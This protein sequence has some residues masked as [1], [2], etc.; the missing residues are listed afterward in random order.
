MAASTTTPAQA[1]K[2]F[3]TAQ[4]FADFLNQHWKNQRI[5]SPKSVGGVELLGD[6][7]GDQWLNWYAT[8]S[9]Q[10]PG[11]PLGDFEMTFFEIA[12][13]ASLG[14]AVSAAETATGQFTGQAANATASGLEQ[15]AK[16]FAPFTSVTDFLNALANPHLWIRVVKVIAGGVILI[17]GLVK[18]TGLDSRAPAVVRSAVKA[19]P[20]L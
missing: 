16:T 1:Q 7:V 13:A 14:K 18:L 6:N 11:M 8:V 12:V 4:S 2:D 17:V 3:P 20:L 19:A 10:H 9:P 15:T 5:T